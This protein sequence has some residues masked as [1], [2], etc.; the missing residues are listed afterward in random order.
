MIG[1]AVVTGM[2]TAI[3]RFRPNGGLNPLSYSPPRMQLPPGEF[4]EAPVYAR[5]REPAAPARVRALQ[6]LRFAANPSGVG[7][8]IREHSRSP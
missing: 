7:A 6:L 3:K 8:N 5:S 4:P 1:I 2:A